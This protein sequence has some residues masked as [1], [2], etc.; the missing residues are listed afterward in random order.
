MLRLLKM[1]P[2]SDGSI[3]EIAVKIDWQ[4]CGSPDAGS[5]YFTSPVPWN[6]N[7][8]TV[9]LQLTFL[10]APWISNEI[11]SSTN[12]S[13]SKPSVGIIKPDLMLRLRFSIFS[14]V[15]MVW[16]IMLSFS[17]SEKVAGNK[18]FWLWSIGSKL[19]KSCVPPG[20][21][22]RRR[23]IKKKSVRACTLLLV[24]LLEAFALPWK[25]RRQRRAH[26]QKYVSITAGLTLTRR[27]RV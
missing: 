3:A 17:S 18:S 5:L 1:S 16:L 19:L 25:M 15:L 9:L 2:L 27:V 6:V 22:R 23:V 11:V 20:S 7:T 12:E 24:P 21:P 14:R 8:Y 4:V 10:M 13:A 26:T